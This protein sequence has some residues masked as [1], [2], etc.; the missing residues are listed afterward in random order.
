MR[1]HFESALKKCFVTTK[2]RSMF[3][4]IALLILSRAEITLSSIEGTPHDLTTKQCYLCHTP[5]TNETERP[6]WDISQEPKISITY[7]F[8]I[9]DKDDAQETPSLSCFCLSCHNGVLGKLVKSRGSCYISDIT[10][11]PL[12]NLYR[13]ESDSWNSHPHLIRFRYNPNQN[14]NNNN[15]PTVVS[16]PENPL[17]K[18]IIG[19]RTGTFYPLYGIHN[20]QFECTTCHTAHYTNLRSFEIRHHKYILRTSGFSMCSDCHL[21]K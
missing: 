13:S 5:K 16:L 6:L 4:S 21:N 7:N 1:I 12:E 19:K 20:D 14:I 10:Y 17:K 8:L 11:E 9:H 2:K 18:G 3:F 15:F